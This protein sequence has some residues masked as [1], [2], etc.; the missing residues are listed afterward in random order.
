MTVEQHLTLIF[1]GA[2]VI[3]AALTFNYMALRDRRLDRPTLGLH[4]NPFDGFAFG[5]IV[6]VLRC[7]HAGWSLTEI[8]AVK[9][10]GSRLKKTAPDAWQRSF[11]VFPP[12]PIDLV[13]TRTGIV[14]FILEQA[15]PP[16]P[17]MSV[18]V[19]CKLRTP[20]GRIVPVRASG[21]CP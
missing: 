14:S 15:D 1:S 11:A 3:I 21:H 12:Q 10:N 17:G 6:Q 7:E 13:H 5:C 4:I 8:R 16:Y 18:T 2:A 19:E 9:P 20:S